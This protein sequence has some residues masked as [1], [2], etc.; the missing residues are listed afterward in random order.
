MS[1]VFNARDVKIAMG[2]HSTPFENRCACL[3][4]PMAMFV[5]LSPISEAG[6][7]NL[8][9]TDILIVADSHTAFPRIAT[10]LLI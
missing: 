2:M 6:S 7:Y 1:P 10:S 3:S 5:Y 4:R 8:P 9:H